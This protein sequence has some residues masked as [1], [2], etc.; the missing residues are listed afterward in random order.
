MCVNRLR[1]GFVFAT[2]LICSS[3]ST[4][5]D[6]VFQIGLAGA[7]LN[8]I[9]RGGV[10]AD[11]STVVG[12]SHF[13]SALYQPFR[14]TKM[15]GTVALAD[16]AAAWSP[17]NASADGSVIVGNG[18][19]GGYVWT[20]STGIV[21]I[22]CDVRQVS[23]DGTTVIGSCGRWKEATGWISLGQP[24]GMKSSLPLTV[25]FD[26]SV[27][28]GGFAADDG[29][30]GTFRWTEATGMVD[31]GIL[32]GTINSFP[33]AATPDG[34][35]VV[36][37]SYGATPYTTKPYKGF[38][39]S[40]TRGLQELAGAPQGDDVVAIGVSADGA[41]VV[42]TMGDIDGD[43]ATQPFRWTAATGI[44]GLGLPSGAEHAYAIAVSG[45]GSVVAGG[46]G[47]VA[48]QDDDGG[49]RWTEQEGIQSLADILAAKGIDLDGWTAATAYSI[50]GD[51]SLIGF[52]T[53]KPGQPSKQHV[54]DA[55]R[56]SRSRHGNLDETDPTA[57][58]W[59]AHLSSPFVSQFP[60]DNVNAATAET[61]RVFDHSMR[62]IKA[63]SRVSLNACDGEI[64]AFTGDVGERQFGY[65]GD[66][67]SAGPGYAAKGGS[68]FTLKGLNYVGDQYGPQFLESDHQ[69]GYDYEVPFG[70]NVYSAVAGAIGYPKRIVGRGRQELHA[71]A[72][73][74]IGDPTYRIYY[75]YL[76][77]HPDLPPVSFPGTPQPGCYKYPSGRDFTPKT[78]PLKAG[79]RVK[80]GCLVALSGYAE[81][82]DSP[83]LHL[84]VQRAYRVDQVSAGA[85]APN[86]RCLYSDPSHVC[87]P[88]DPYGW[89]G[90]PTDCSQSD[91]SKWSGDIY[92]C[93]TG[94]SSVNLW[95]SGKTAGGHKSV[96][97]H[98]HH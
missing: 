1:L 16:P 43:T 33:S 53:Y 91:P 64:L 63:S 84:E 58:V 80:A 86:L 21:T 3:R 23:G 31:L 20:E 54:Y 69:T 56:R 35:A 68:G 4:L 40:S 78:L 26:G 74:P 81:Q 36:G 30:T 82:Q 42:G 77:T 19:N 61:L 13:P 62:S 70:S 25:S 37:T 65:D 44:V 97:G 98:A 6:S 17:P 67:C 9:Y 46:S 14:W 87:L 12:I 85:R 2:M 49:F 75:F 11:G 8:L 7:D 18:P 96:H 41:N 66:A 71:L 5:A 72:L 24:A 15:T 38:V 95:P 32:P 76:S 59:V 50:S 22:G 60:L 73:I 90:E 39:W 92:E 27:V 10:S 48:A 79:T 55:S 57:G 34:S 45:D 88:L 94:I 51:G 47:S 28:V 52:A 83:R 93:L 89:T 29:H